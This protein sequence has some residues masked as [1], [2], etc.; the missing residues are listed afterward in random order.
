[1]Y[2]ALAGVWLIFAL[3]WLALLLNQAARL[4][5]QVAALSQLTGRCRQDRDQDQDQEEEEGGALPASL[6]DPPK[7]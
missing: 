4:L 7:L 1:M 6:Q 3:A 2:R 5:R